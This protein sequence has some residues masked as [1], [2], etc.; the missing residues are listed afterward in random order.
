MRCEE[1]DLIEVACMKR[2]ILN[3]TTP[4]KMYQGMAKDIVYN[5]Q[6]TQCLLIEQDGQEVLIEMDSILTLTSLTQNP[7]FKS[8]NFKTEN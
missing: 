7:F 2:F 4:S 6:Q 3:V 1:T 5:S 8:I